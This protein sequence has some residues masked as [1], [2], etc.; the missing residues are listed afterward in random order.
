MTGLRDCIVTVTLLPSTLKFAGSFRSANRLEAL[1]SCGFQPAGKVAVNGP[2][3][4]EY[5]AM[6]SSPKGQNVALSRATS[7]PSSVTL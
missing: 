6:R 4:M 1:T 7:A 2:S 3:A 5:I